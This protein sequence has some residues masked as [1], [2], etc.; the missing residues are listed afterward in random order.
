MKESYD[1]KTGHIYKICLDGYYTEEEAKHELIRL[2]RTDFF[3]HK[4]AV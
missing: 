3:A 2:Y 1:I 4:G